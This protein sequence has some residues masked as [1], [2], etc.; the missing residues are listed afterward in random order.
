MRGD[1]AQEDELF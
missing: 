1:F